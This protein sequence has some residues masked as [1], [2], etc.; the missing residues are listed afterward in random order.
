MKRF[1]NILLL[2]LTGL[3]A[4]C[5]NSTPSDSLPQKPQNAFLNFLRQ[6]DSTLVEY[7]ALSFDS[8][9]LGN[10]HY[11]DTSVFN[12]SDHDRLSSYNTLFNTL[13]NAGSAAK[14]MR[15]T[16]N[17]NVGFD[18]SVPAYE[19]Y[20]F[21][22]SNMPVFKS[23][24]PYSE[25]RYL[26]TAI[27][28]EQNFRVRFGMQ[29][30][31]RFYIS[32]GFDFDYSPGIYKNNQTN[33]NDVWVNAHYTIPS[34]RYAVMAYYFRN[35]IDNQENGGIVYDTVYTTHQESDNA[36]IIT[37]LTNATNHVVSSGFGLSH[38]FNLMPN[39][40]MPSR[41]SDRK[42][43]ADTLP[44]QTDTLCLAI[45]TIAADTLLVAIDTTLAI[46][47]VLT[48][49][50]EAVEG[51]RWRF[52][53]GR[54]GHSF[55]YTRNKIFF[56][57][58]SPAVSFYAPFGSL[59]D[60]VA[61][62][63]STIMRSVVN[64]VKWSNLAYDKYD[65]DVPLYLYAE[66]GYG[67]Y[68][69]SGMHDYASNE[70]LD[71]RNFSQ[72][73][74]SGGAELNLF[75]S[76]HL[77]AKANLV[78]AGYQAGD[79]AVDAEWQQLFGTTKKNYGRLEFR[80]NMKRQSASW[81]EQSYYSNHFSWDN[82]FGAATYLMFDAAYRYKTIAVGVKHTSI[83][84]LIY[85]G[86]E[87][88]PVQHDGFCSITE[89][90]A[91]YSYAI[92]RFEF[93][94]FSSLQLTQADSP[95]HLPLFLTRLKLA[96]AQPVFHKAAILQPSVTVQYF[97]K[98]YADAYMPALRVFYQQNEVKIGN[99]PFVDL[100]LSIKVKRANLFVEY[101]NMIM[102]TPYRESFTTPHYPYRDGRLF[103]G[104]NWR[105]FN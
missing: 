85:F 99:Y 30:Q 67:F 13:S 2:L 95:V 14:A 57:E 12:A 39:P 45:D 58:S 91:T 35:K 73:T 103:L 87:A 71:A 97:T 75:K 28:K 56:N 90:Y 82:D 5:Q 52:S 83:N 38:Y 72:A 33:N 40:D 96:Y 66:A 37:N 70:M 74:V 3:S 16:Y 77:T 22:S 27:D 76:S 100:A 25:L 34:G 94:G 7:T 26:M 23:V 55:A 93:S 50:D 102:L 104:V 51:K 19:P 36:V 11:V 1:L 86:P 78:V 60:S 61:T 59:L 65:G 92:K 17:H 10:K 8:V 4:V 64:S 62:T 48:F 18:M 41:K 101:S 20:F 89:V 31:P 24:L 49:T 84:N 88:R 105:L 6:T 43:H 42:H 15:F 63:D 46:D 80:F 9:F 69:I 29:V 54:L 81:F 79:F 47:T 68:K 98:Y 44:Q 32:F 53:L 21:N